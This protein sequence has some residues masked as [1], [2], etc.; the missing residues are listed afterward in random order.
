MPRRNR[1]ERRIIRPDP[2]Y[3]DQQVQILINKVMTRGK[4]STAERVVYGAFDRIQENTGRDPVDTFRQAMRNATPVLEVKPRRVGGTTYQVPVEIRPER[5]TALAMRWL[6]QGARGRGGHTMA[7]RLAA[8][9]LDAANNA[10]SA[11]KRRDDT[12][13]MAEANRAFVHYRW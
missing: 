6:L 12:H 7:E 5:R 9:L 11:I 2:R 4:K 3:G 13:R 10:G 1:P 8:E